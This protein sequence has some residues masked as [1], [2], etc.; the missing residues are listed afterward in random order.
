MRFLVFGSV[1]IDTRGLPRP[2]VVNVSGPHVE[3]GRVLVAIAL[4]STKRAAVEKW[5]ARLGVPVVEAVR[6]IYPGDPLPLEIAA[7]VEADGYQVT[8]YIR[9][10]LPT[11]EPVKA[12]DPAVCGKAAG[13]AAL[14]ARAADP[15]TVLWV[16]GSKDGYA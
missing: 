10:A 4:E 6:P 3:G 8:V 13:L 15:D 14:T 1:E 2:L 5:A 16:V 7:V 11:S 9:V 12:D